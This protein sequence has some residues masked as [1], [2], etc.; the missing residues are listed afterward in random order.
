MSIQ[1]ENSNLEIR[2]T[3]AIKSF[4]NPLSEITVPAWRRHWIMKERY[5]TM[6]AA[7]IFFAFATVTYLLHFF[8]V[9]VPAG[10]EPM[11][12][13]FGY[14][15]GLASFSVVGF[16][17]TFSTRFS[18][19]RFYKVPLILAT[20]L[21]SYLQ[22]KSMEWA[23]AT[24]MFFAYLIPCIM[25]IL[26]KLSVPQSLG[27]FVAI[28][29]LQYPILV[30]T[31]IEGHILTSATMISMV[32][33]VLFRSGMAADVRNFMADK[34]QKEL[35]RQ[36]NHY[37]K[38]SQRKG[39]D[40][41]Q[42]NAY[43]GRRALELK[44]LLEASHALAKQT[45]MESLM[46]SSLVWLKRLFVGGRFF[47]V[48]Y[49]DEVTKEITIGDCDDHV[50]RFLEVSKNSILAGCFDHESA[51][52][53]GFHIVPMVSGDG[54][55]IGAVA[56]MDLS[57]DQQSFDTLSLFVAEVA[58]FATRVNLVQK[59]EAMAH[60]D[61]L[62]QVFNRNFF[63]ERLSESILKHDRDPDRHFS[64]FLVDVNGLK[65]VNDNYGHQYGDALIKNVATMLKSSCR[66]SDVVSRIGGDEFVILCPETKDASKLLSRIRRHERERHLQIED[67]DGML[68]R[69][70][71]RMS[72][73][74]S[75]TLH[76]DAHHVMQEADESMY[77]DKR[78]F[79]QT[80]GFR[81]QK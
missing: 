67:Q 39:E 13:W 45:D 27:L 41:K 21:F 63:D 32:I 73:G 72:I 47:V 12:L 51:S 38:E 37:L 74:V 65:E 35:R 66:R 19:G 78:S 15:F 50:I 23:D 2:K 33:I 56:V 10:K 55:P 43:L 31:A 11:A 20:F 54:F 28:Q 60:V 71:V 40:L 8:L 69:V 36:L 29:L 24:P 49:K 1:T 17:L 6:F 7:R 79:Y 52:K 30:N 46:E 42:K 4:L 53:L 26:L 16:L 9:D 25:T 81:R 70:P 18:A 34:R 3:S 61:G 77:K 75:S 62:T 59:L 68:V 22:A 76:T 48:F 64:V 44:L 14:R 57:L 5:R 58:G 80:R